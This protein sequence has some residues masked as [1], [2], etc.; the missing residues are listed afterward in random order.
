ML[1]PHN[2]GGG[3]LR[4]PITCLCKD[5]AVHQLASL[6]HRTPAVRAAAVQAI[7]ATTQRDDETTTNGQAMDGDWQPYKRTDFLRSYGLQLHQGSQ[8]PDHMC[9]LQVRRRSGTLHRPISSFTRT[10]ID[11]SGSS[12][13]DYRHDPVHP[14]DSRPWPAHAWANLAPI[15]RKVSPESVRAQSLIIHQGI[16]W[17][18]LNSEQ[19]GR[20]LPSRQPIY[21]KGRGSFSAA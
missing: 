15:G 9:D 17:C 14:G 12:V 18:A 6:Q 11:K 8:Q 21:A 3:G 2:L 16:A 5:L 20:W 7:T 4:N 10:I 19:A 13:A 1:L